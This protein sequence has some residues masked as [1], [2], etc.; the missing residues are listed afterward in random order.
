MPPTQNYPTVHTLSPPAAFPI[1]LPA[2]GKHSSVRLAELFADRTLVE[3]LGIQ[4][5]VIPG[6]PGFDQRPHH[7]HA[8][9]EGEFMRASR[10]F[11][12]NVCLSKAAGIVAVMIACIPAAAALEPPIT[13]EPPI[14]EGEVTL[15]ALLDVTSEADRLLISQGPRDMAWYGSST[16]YVRDRKRGGAGKRV[17]VRVDLGGSRSLKKK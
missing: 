17:S 2:V 5:V 13:R 12:R 6:R 9:L 4:T 14:I 16:A 10:L 11:A 7:T 3:Y 1:L 15:Q 8:R